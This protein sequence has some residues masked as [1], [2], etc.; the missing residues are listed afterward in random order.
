MTASISSNERFHCSGSSWPP[1]R[2]H[3]WIEIKELKGEGTLELERLEE[4][5]YDD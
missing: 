1:G 3:V 5:G 4:G 2:S